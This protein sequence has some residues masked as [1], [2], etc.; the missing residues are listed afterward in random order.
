[1]EGDSGGRHEVKSR[2]P[3]DP[4]KISR[5][6]SRH[7]TPLQSESA[8]TTLGAATTSLLGAQLQRAAAAAA[9]AQFQSGQ[10]QQQQQTQGQSLGQQQGQGQGQSQQQQQSNAYESSTGEYSV[11]VAMP[12]YYGSYGSQSAQQTTTAATNTATSTSQQHQKPQLQSPAA[13]NHNTPTR[14]SAG[15]YSLVPSLA[16]HYEDGPTS[17]SLPLSHSPYDSITRSSAGAS[18]GAG[19]GAGASGLM[20]MYAQINPLSSV[21]SSLISA[22]TAAASSPPIKPSS[23]AAGSVATRTRKNSAITITGSP[24]TSASPLYFNHQSLLQ[25]QQHQQ[26]QQ[27]Q[28]QH[29]MQQHQQQQQQFQRHGSL[30][31]E[32]LIGDDD[33]GGDAGGKM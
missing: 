15:Q 14:F 20:G 32:S 3:R 23:I 1:M 22:A 12:Q 33:I 28:H 30:T 25:Q 24:A 6:Q 17:T 26:Q 29:Q 9:A 18:V 4:K 13:T 10:G 27:Q 19:A 31:N 8:A 5:I 2:W 7:M 16:T 21:N 11:G